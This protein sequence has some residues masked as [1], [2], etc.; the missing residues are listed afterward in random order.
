MLNI[1]IRGAQLELY[2]GS[3]NEQMKQDLLKEIRHKKR[4]LAEIM[5]NKNW[6]SYNDIYSSV[7]PIMSKD[8]ELIVTAF[9]SDDYYDDGHSFYRTK[10]IDIAQNPIDETIKFSAKN[11]II[12]NYAIY[13]GC[14]FE[15]ELN[16]LGYKYFDHNLLSVTTSICPFFNVPIINELFLNRLELTDIQR[17]KN[18][19]IKY[20]SVIYTNVKPGLIEQ[21]FKDDLHKS[22]EKLIDAEIDIKQ[23]KE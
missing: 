7:S 19:M 5:L 10:I 3:I 12:V 23:T 13:Y 21:F 2:V 15:T 22:F 17:Q 11:S 20:R 8:S 1:Q 18:E 6:K 16:D 14:S 4:S 9:N